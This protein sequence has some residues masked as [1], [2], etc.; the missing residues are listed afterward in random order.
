M[1]LHSKNFFLTLKVFI[2]SSLG[3]I[4]LIGPKKSAMMWIPFTGKS[5]FI[6]ILKFGFNQRGLLLRTSGPRTSSFSYSKATYHILPFVSGCL[7]NLLKII[8]AIQ[9]GI[10]YI[11]IIRISCLLDFIWYTFAQQT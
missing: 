11:K 1:E 7:E 10:T 6:R 2:N 4:H 3:I 9:K 8:W 5:L